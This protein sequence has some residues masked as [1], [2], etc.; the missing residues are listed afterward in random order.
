MTFFWND[1]REN[2][3]PLL[4][5]S[6]DFTDREDWRSDSPLLQREASQQSYV[7]AADLTI[8]WEQ[9]ETKELS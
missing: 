8:I 6:S 3:K 9:I 1:L 2:I 4:F 7:W 5:L